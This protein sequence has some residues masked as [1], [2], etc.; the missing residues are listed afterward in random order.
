MKKIIIVSLLASVLTGGAFAQVT[1][2]GSVYAGVR[3]QSTQ[4]T[5]ETIGA[6]HREDNF[7]REPRFDLTVTVMR[8]DY[9][10]RLDT[11]FQFLGPGD[12]NN[13]V[14]NG[15]YGW[16]NFFDNS[17][18]LTM[19]RISSPA[20]VTRLDASLPEHFFDEITGFR[21]EYTT[22]I[23]GLSVGAAFRTEGRDLER[24]GQ[25]AIFGLNFIHPMFTTVFAYELGRNVRTLFGFNFIGISDLSAGLQLRADRIASWD[26]A[27]FEG[28]LQVHYKIG[29]RVM[30]PLFVYLIFGQ[31]F[32][33][34]SNVGPYWEIT[35][36]VTY[37]FMPNLTGALS[38]TLDNF[39]GNPNNNLTINTS[40]EHTLRGPAIFYVEYELRLDNMDT[41]TH[42]FGFGITIMAF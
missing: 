19:G 23:Q 41:A 10:A 26:E 20:W 16:I 14:L 37:R 24:L 35:P 3:F 39:D 9:G 12:E 5:D 25:E 13:F 31:R 38:M 18:R 15:I 28:I 33:G 21:V 17:V 42:T 4:D 6:F 8:E 32:H 29:Y 7:E 11:S 40:L 1:F 30:R 34:E 27:P 22:P 2:S 36:G